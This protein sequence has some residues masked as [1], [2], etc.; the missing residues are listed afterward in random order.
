MHVVNRQGNTGSV[1][2]FRCSTLAPIENVQLPCADVVVPPFFLSFR[3][4]LRRDPIVWEGSFGKGRLGD[5]IQYCYDS[6][7]SEVKTIKVRWEQ[8]RAMN[9][10]RNR[11]SVD[12]IRH[13]RRRRHHHLGCRWAPLLLQRNT[14]FHAERLDVWFESFRFSCHP[15]SIALSKAPVA[16]S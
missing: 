7:T 14:F 6:H 1:F 8:R 12:R 9:G 10:K 3:I 13:R 15:Q 4:L 2:T 5:R 16:C 11:T